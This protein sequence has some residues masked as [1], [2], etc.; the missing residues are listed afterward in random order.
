MAKR[1][2][3]EEFEAEV[4]KASL[5]VIVEFYSD[6]CI[7]CKQLSPVLG[8]IEDDYEDKLIVV[9]V[10]V[11]FDA[12]LAQKYEVAA[13]P[14]PFV[15]QRGKRS[16]PNPRSCKAERVRRSCRGNF[17]K[18]DMKMVVTVAGEKKTYDEGLTIAKLIEVEKVE[19]PDYVT[20][21]VNDEFVE[22]TD[23]AT[24]ALKEN[25]VVEFLYFMGGGAS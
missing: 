9:K 5:P 14:N 11:N 17:I 22:S 25:D 2:N 19:N 3:A 13:S 7:P 23:F 10:N 15:F 8:G 16:K 12:E 21:T 1:V 18:E 24:T 6:S 4:L 20:V